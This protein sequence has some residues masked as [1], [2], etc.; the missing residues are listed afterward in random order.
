MG[1]VG[2]NTSSIPE[3]PTD[4]LTVDEILDTL[5]SEFPDAPP[6][7]HRA[8]IRT[9]EGTYRYVGDPEPPRQSERRYNDNYDIVRRRGSYWVDTPLAIPHG[10]LVRAGLVR[11]MGE[12]R[13]EGI[14]PTRNGFRN[15]NSH[16]P[17]V[18]GEYRHNLTGRLFRYNPNYR[19]G[20]EPTPW[21]LDNPPYT[22]QE[23]LDDIEDYGVRTR[24]VSTPAGDVEVIESGDM[25]AGEAVAL[26]S[27]D[28]ILYA[29]GAT[30]SAVH[31]EPGA[32]AH[33]RDADFYTRPGLRLPDPPRSTDPSPLERPMPNTQEDIRPPIQNIMANTRP[34][35]IPRTYE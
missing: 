31:I 5:R 1:F 8:P 6:K 20:W 17:P 23:E 24:R 4:A 13:P 30:V 14:P 12:A 34:V 11:G 22:V 18:V 10:S 19:D 7:F 29:Q 27:E 3:P 35:I 28:V 21:S 33:L 15:I 25:P 2:L 26:N 32:V 9:P 16:F